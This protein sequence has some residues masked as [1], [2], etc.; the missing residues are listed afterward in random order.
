MKTPAARPA[1]RVIGLCLI[2]AEVLVINLFSKAG[3]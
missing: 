2:T 3:H 1:G